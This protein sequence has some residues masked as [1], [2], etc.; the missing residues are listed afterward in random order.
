MSK[1]KKNWEQRLSG[2]PD[3]LTVA[4]VESLSLDK[5]LYKYDIAG[6]AAHAEMLAEQNLISKSELKAIKK[7]LSEIRNEMSSGKFKFDKELEDI[8]MVIEDALIK[9]IGKPGKKLHTGR[10]RNDQV[11][12]DIRLWMRDEIELLVKKLTS[13]EKSLVELAGKHARDV[14]PGFT[15]LQHAQPVVVGSYLLSFVERFER[16]IL[17]LNNCSRIVNVSPLGSGALAGSTLG[18]DRKSTAE[19]LGFKDISQNSI[20]AV[21]DRDFCAEF[22]FDCALIAMHLSQ[23]AEDWIIYSSEEFGFLRLDDSFCTSSSM[24]P[25]KRNPDLLELIRSRTGRVYGSLMGILTVLKA[26]PTGYNRD[27]QEDKFHIFTASDMIDS[28]IEAA[29]AIVLGTTFNTEKLAA[30]LDKGF[31]DATALAEY[32]V[33]KGV[34][35]RQAHGIV[36]SIVNFCEEQNKAL[37]D[38]SLDEF[39]AYSEAVERDVYENLGSEKVARKYITEGAAGQQQTEQRVSYWREQL[40]KR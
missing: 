15:H 39:K 14:M 29:A 23:L 40:S 30:K 28:S 13:L 37:S 38:L 20:D 35:F 31:L 6:S 16:D 25:Q 2:T 22:I 19:K 17:R 9:K 33:N 3:K 12:T 36:G 34:P 7:G 4:F 8:H 32:L 1:Q 18:L 24:M 21:S 27:L 5:R 11:S 10:S 26:Q